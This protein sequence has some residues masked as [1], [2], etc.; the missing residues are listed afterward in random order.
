MCHA[1][2][3]VLQA[4]VKMVRT[5]SKPEMNASREQ[6]AGSWKRKGCRRQGWKTHFHF[7]AGSGCLPQWTRLQIFQSRGIKQYSDDLLIF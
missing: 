2:A 3:S 4:P 1:S 7:W 5:G 6:G